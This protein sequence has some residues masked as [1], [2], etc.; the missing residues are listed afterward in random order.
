MGQAHGGPD[1]QGILD[2]RDVVRVT[3]QRLDFSLGRVS[4]DRGLIGYVS[5]RLPHGAE[6]PAD[7]DLYALDLDAPSG[8]FPVDGVAVAGG[9][10]QEEQFAPVGL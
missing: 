7:L 3:Q 4:L 1:T 5:G 10:R 6:L 8:G 9:Q 2:L